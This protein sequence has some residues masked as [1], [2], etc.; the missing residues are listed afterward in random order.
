MRLFIAVNFGQEMKESLIDAIGRLRAVSSKG[1]FTRAANLHLTLAFIGETDRID[2]ISAVMTDAA[3]QTP[4]FDISLGEQGHFRRGSGDIRWVGIG[5]GASELSE[6]SSR[7]TS[8]LIA[9]GFDV[10]RRFTPH[11]TLGR[12]VSAPRR[13]DTAPQPAKSR[14]DKVSL[15]RSD[16]VNGAL[17]YTEIFSAPLI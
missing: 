17:K 3:A 15:M 2:D 11:I 8:G 1:N 9:V 6:L 4:A 14:V 7:L 13:A 16:R 5:E 10:D 12:E